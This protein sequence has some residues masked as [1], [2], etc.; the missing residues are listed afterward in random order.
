MMAY[1]VFVYT[2]YNSQDYYSSL[3]TAT[4]EGEEKEV[5]N[6]LQDKIKPCK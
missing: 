3:T 1:F 6:Y 2:D 5:C 4:L